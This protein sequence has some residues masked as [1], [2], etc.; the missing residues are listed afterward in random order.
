MHVSL[1]ALSRTV[2]HVL[3]AAA[4]M[5]VPIVRRSLVPAAMFTF[6]VYVKTLAGSVALRVTPSDLVGGVKHA[7]CTCASERLE[8]AGQPLDDHRTLASYRIQPESTLDVKGRLC[9]G[10]ARSGPSTSRPH[11][12]RPVFSPECTDSDGA[13]F[14]DSD[15][16]EAGGYRS[17]TGTCGSDALYRAD[18]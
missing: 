5:I 14:T 13:V 6:V 1:R 11:S 16:Q 4:A 7:V 3:A 18:F 17:P 10:G 9:G 15:D 2:C 12:S 8:Y